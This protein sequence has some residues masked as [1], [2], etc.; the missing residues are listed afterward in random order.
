MRWMAMGILFSLRWEL[1]IVTYNLW[2]KIHFFR[3]HEA[4]AV[5][6]KYVMG[7]WSYNSAVAFSLVSLSLF[8]F[9]ISTELRIK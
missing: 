9:L 3:L 1:V 5:L 7:V 4:S 6:N 8:L 2:N